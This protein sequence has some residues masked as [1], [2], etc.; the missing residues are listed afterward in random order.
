MK[1]YFFEIKYIF[2][3]LLC[4]AA[5]VSVFVSKQKAAEAFMAEEKQNSVVMNEEIPLAIEYLSNATLPS[6][7]FVYLTNLN[8]QVK[9]NSKK[10]NALRH[11]GTLY[12]MYLCEKYLN[13]YTLQKRRYK[14]SE[15]FIKNYVKRISPDMFAVVSKMEEEKLDSPQA[16]L[17]GSGLALIGLS[18]LYP[19]KKIDLE[20]LRG[21]GNFIIY[22]QKSDGS[23]YS[24]YLV[25]SKQKDENFVSLYYPGEAALGLLYLYDVDPQPKWIAASK[26]TLLYLADSRKNKG[27]DVPFDHWAM[28]ATKKLFETQ[29]NTLTKDEK[30]ILQ[31]HAAQ[32]ANSILPKQIT[33]PKDPLAG[34][35]KGNARLCSIGTMMEGL[36]AIYAVV[37]D[38]DLK[39]R[40]MNGLRLG[41]RFLGRYQVKDGSKK[42]GLPNNAYWRSAKA[43]KKSREIRIDNV[44]HVLSAWITFNELFK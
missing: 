4:A 31:K 29:N 38:E 28:L 42:G 22:M 34:S 20:T 2:I 11:A 12:S 8:P 14:A 32:M 24:K 16:K 27:T 7:R 43:N 17:G 13:D 15:Y 19:D 26:K 1:N 25:E 39:Y 10:Y 44:Q 35:F 5:F 36:V 41:T 37:D 18:N 30:I 40:V 3:L 6:G 33:D 23:F 9:Y 21:L